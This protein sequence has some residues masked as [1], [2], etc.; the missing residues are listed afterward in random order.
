MG[1][2]SDNA[3]EAQ[4]DG[5]NVPVGTIRDP[6]TPDMSFP[7]RRDLSLGPAQMGVSGSRPVRDRKSYDVNLY[8]REKGTQL[9]C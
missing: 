4:P 8:L 2:V 1:L 9:Y 6:D 5:T 3:R 7:S